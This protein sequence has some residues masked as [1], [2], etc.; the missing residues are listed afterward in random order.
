MLRSSPSFSLTYATSSAVGTGL[1]AKNTA[2]SP[3][4]RRMMT[5]VTT[6][7]PTTAGIAARTRRMMKRRSVIASSPDRPA[8]VAIYAGRLVF[9]VSRQRADI[10]ERVEP[11]LIICD[12]C[13]NHDFQGCLAEE[14]HRN[15]LVDDRDHLAH[16]RIVGHLIGR[17]VG[18]CDQRVERRVGVAAEIRSSLS[19]EEDAHPIVR[20]VEPRHLVLEIKRHLLGRLELA[21][22]R[23][24][25]LLD[26]NA[27]A[28][29][30]QMVLERHGKVLEILG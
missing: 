1:E 18:L 19:L 28:G 27:N 10:G 29:A 21:E 30:C 22:T 17:L 15:V 14:E 3:G 24:R 13:A 2:G 4:R 25:I 7:S 23:T 5:K 6:T 26:R 20:Q 11:I 16:R 9:S 8:G 12:V